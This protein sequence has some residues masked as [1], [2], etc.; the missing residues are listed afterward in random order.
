MLLLRVQLQEP[1][2]RGGGGGGGGDG[3]GGGGGGGGGRGVGGGGV[4]TR[5]GLLSV[6]DLAGSERVSKSGSEGVRLWRA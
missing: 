5:R 6:V 3:G 4:V 2:G 1:A